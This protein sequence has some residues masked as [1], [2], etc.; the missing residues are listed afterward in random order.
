MHSLLHAIVRLDG[1]AL[2]MQ[3]GEPPYV[4]TTAGRVEVGSRGLPYDVIAELLWELA[5]KEAH[6]T[7]RTA[8]TVQYACPFFHDLS[9]EHFTVVATSA[10]D[11]LRVVIRRHLAKTEQ[12]VKT[13][14]PQNQPT[15]P[16]TLRPRGVHDNVALLSHRTRARG[17]LIHGTGG[18]PAPA[19]E[20]PQ[21]ARRFPPL[22]LYVEDSLDQ[23]DLYEVVLSGRYEFIGASDGRTGVELAT[24]RQPDVIL[25]DLSMPHMDGWEVCQR[26]KS[27]PRTAAIPIIVLTAHDGVDIEEKATRLGVAGLLRKPCP[28][29]VLRDH[30]SQAIEPWMT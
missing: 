19:H 20:G 29:D 24:T 16:S 2:M 5:P 17:S 10:D 26:L 11:D 14:T 9:A 28:V 22:V 18:A 1:A 7:L 25:V 23:L 27:D 6:A 21:V 30:I 13:V 3:V 4:V 12:P 8:G 15:V